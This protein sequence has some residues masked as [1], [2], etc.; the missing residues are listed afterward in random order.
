MASLWLL[1]HSLVRMVK[2]EY[3]TLGA[4]MQ[5]QI[6]NAPHVRADPSQT[7]R[8]RRLRVRLGAEW[9]G[10]SRL[11]LALLELHDYVQHCRLV[12]HP[13]AVVL[14]RKRMQNIPEHI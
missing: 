5:W 13:M 12:P 7:K 10:Q 6:Y 8:G 1:V 4:V 2:W 3:E 11:S 9:G 14:G